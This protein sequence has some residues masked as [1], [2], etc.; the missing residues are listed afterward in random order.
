MET[1]YAN[2]ALERS[3]V[4]AWEGAAVLEFGADWCG[5]CQAAQPVLA[6]A[7]QSAGDFKHVKIEDGPGRRLGRSFKVKRWPTFVFLK[8]GAE[9]A[10]TE[11]PTKA[12]EIRQGLQLIES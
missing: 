9:V 11:R 4:D 1:A 10:R 7:L 2:Q 8:D 12:D 6:E 3:E 5:H